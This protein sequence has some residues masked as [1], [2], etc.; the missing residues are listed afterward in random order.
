MLQPPKFTGSPGVIV[1][2]EEKSP[3]DF[4]QLFFS[5]QILQLIH[6]ETRR[7]AQQYLEREREREREHLEQHPKA[8]AHEWT[9]IPFTL[10]EDCNTYRHGYLWISHFEVRLH[11]LHIAS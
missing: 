6:T 11:Y 10:K 2:M 8:R 5:S 7:Y 4:F 3:V 9:R 1:G